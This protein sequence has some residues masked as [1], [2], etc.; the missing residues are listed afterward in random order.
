[1]PLILGTNSIKDTGYNVA[2]SLRFDDGGSEYLQRT[3]SST[4]NRKT[5]TF[6]T[7]IK[8]SGIGLS[9][10]MNV[11]GGEDGASRYTDIMIGTPSG[12]DDT[13][14]FKQDTGTVAE[15]RSTLKL[16]DPSACLLYTSPSPRDGL[17]SRMPSSA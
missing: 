6:S 15:L 10:P 1:M 4:G 16:R 8:R 7:W 14:W 17:L 11:F 2:N 5:W 12:A 13:F 3:P 9:A